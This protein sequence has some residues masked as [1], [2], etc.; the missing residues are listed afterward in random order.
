MLALEHMTIREGYQHASHQEISG[1]IAEMS[2]SHH[3]HLQKVVDMFISSMASLAYS[4]NNQ[5]SV[6]R[7]SVN[8]VA[9]PQPVMVAVSQL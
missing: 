9:E 4:I 2:K 6:S 8:T 3:L 5:A 1:K 7:H